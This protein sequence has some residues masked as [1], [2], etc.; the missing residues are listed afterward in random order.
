M[1]K[2]VDRQQSK[3]SMMPGDKENSGSKVSATAQPQM[4]QS[5]MFHHNLPCQYLDL[6]TTGE[7]VER[8]VQ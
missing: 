6:K 3:L 8:E 2:Y 4:L 7:V 1:F 5:T